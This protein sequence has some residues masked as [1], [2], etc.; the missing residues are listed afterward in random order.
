MRPFDVTAITARDQAGSSLAMRPGIMRYSRRRTGLLV[1]FAVLA[2][3][4]SI[5]MGLGCSSSS[6][7]EGPCSEPGEQ[8]GAGFCSKMGFCSGSDAGADA[9]SCM[10][11]RAEGAACSEN[12]ECLSDECAGGKCVNGS[13]PPCAQ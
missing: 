9:M 8:C 13:T 2:C 4:I 12:R 5:G 6:D 10:S 1:S 3:S 11:K 7:Q